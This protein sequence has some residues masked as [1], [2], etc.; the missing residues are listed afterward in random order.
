MNNVGSVYVNQWLGGLGIMSWLLL[1]HFSQKRKQFRLLFQNAFCIPSH[2][3]SSSPSTLLPLPHLSS[4]GPVIPPPPHRPHTMP[5]VR[6]QPTL[7]LWPVY[8]VWSAVCN[9]LYSHTG[10]SGTGPS[11]R[12]TGW[13]HPSIP[14]PVLSVQMKMRES[15]LLW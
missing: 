11:S 10:S 15:S 7:L 1:L 2:L 4:Q 12:P 5:V 6:C 8:G 13:T 3:L 14:V 9:V